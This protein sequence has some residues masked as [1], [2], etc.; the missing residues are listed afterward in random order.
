MSLKAKVVSG[1]KWQAINIIGKQALSLSVFTILARLLGPSD[2]GTIALAGIYLGFVS[3]FA[4][5]GI[6]AA[7]IQRQNL[8][9]AHIDT[10]FW[11]NLIC[12][13]VL[14]LM[15]L[16]FANTLAYLLGNGEL[17]LLLRWL[18]LSLVINAL[19]SVHASLFIKEMDFKRPVIR[20]LIANAA[21]G[22]AG[23]CL[24]L[25]GYGVWALVA[26]QLIAATAGTLFILWTSKYRPS[27]NFSP[28]HLQDLLGVSTSIFA[29]SFVW[30][31]SS[32][33]DQFII[34]RVAGHAALGM[35]VIAGKLPELAKTITM[36]PI[37][38]VSLPALAK[39]Q[40]APAQLCSAIYRG[41]QVNAAIAFPVFFGI[42]CVAPNW[43]PVLFGQSW[44]SAATVSS[45]LSIYTLIVVL[46]VFFYPALLATGGT[47]KFLILNAIHAFGVLVVCTI[48]I[49]YG[50]EHVVIGLILNSL[51]GFIPAL[52][53]LKERIRLSP[54]KYC[55]QCTHPALAALTMAVGIYFADG[56][57]NTFSPANI[58][59]GSIKIILG[60][61][62]YIIYMLIFNRRPIIDLINYFTRTFIS[63]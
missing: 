27:P 24:A 33:L 62:I 18:S 30:F 55:R 9:K 25:L 57:L 20:I 41:M 6:G 36:H 42:A 14:C 34:G 1:L 29:S 16:Q 50:V 12:A 53:I 8:E 13:T 48:G 35:Y 2:F 51:L 54:L 39:L 40:N 63:N 44:A 15:T 46:T 22:S 43:I 56:F 4:D 26:Q 7:L 32:R 59:A 58:T 21:G 5:Q 38:E 37:A 61:L 47:G 31:F 52:Y 60:S 10:A 17:T 28:R 23:I 49:R 3:M 45:L 19:S 11:F